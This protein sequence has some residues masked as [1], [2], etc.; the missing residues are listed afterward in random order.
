M[1]LD[2]GAVP[3]LPAQT[4]VDPLLYPFYL[5]ADM[6]MAFAA[7]LAGGVALEAEEIARVRATSRAVKGLRGSLNL[8]RA[9]IEGGRERENAS[10]RTD[11]STLVRRHTTHSIFIDLHEELQSSGRISTEPDAAELRVGMLVSMRLQPAVA[12][13]RRVIDQ[14][15]R[16]IDVMSPILG[17]SEEPDKPATSRQ[18]RRHQAREAA[19]AATAEQDTNV[20]AT[21]RAMR[22]LFLALRDD[23]DHSG[24]IDIVVA[25]DDGPGVVLTLDKRYADQTALELVHTSGFTVIGKVTQVWPTADDVVLLYRRSVLSLL[26]GL[27]QQVTV[28]LF[29]FLVGLA[30]QIGVADLEQSVQ[31]A[32]GNETT[33]TDETSDEDEMTLDDIML[34]EDIAALHPSLAGPAVQILPL[35]LCV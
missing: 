6:S 13:L 17:N 29:A 9:G 5:D 2:T 28:T 8:F 31:E 22:K 4:R 35:A 15:L 26:P 24:M 3:G 20:P 32:L 30:K 21:L 25:S 19:K 10:G 7:A 27:A 11:E 12:P 14:I 34:G 23:L 33:P 1:P 16:L 18:E